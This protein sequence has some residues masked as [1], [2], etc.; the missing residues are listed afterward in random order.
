MRFRSCA[1]T[2]TLAVTVCLAFH[3]KGS[4]RIVDGHVQMGIA[5]Q[6]QDIDRGFEVVAGF[7]ELKDRPI[8]IGESDPD[9]CAACP[10]TVF[11]QNAYRNGTLYASYT[12]TSYVRTL[13]LA[14]KHG[15]NL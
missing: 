3:A 14:A 5:T 7:K 8:V 12:A 1:I 9:G 10:A 13:D 15:V 6:L 2:T 4:P 11:P